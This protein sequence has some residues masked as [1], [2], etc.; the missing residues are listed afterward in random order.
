M[1]GGNFIK[2]YIEEK[3][4]DTD[5]HIKNWATILMKQ[6][7]AFIFVGFNE[8]QAMHLVEIFWKQCDLRWQWEQEQKRKKLGD[9]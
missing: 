4:K 8:Q 5:E 3:Q 9:E 2:A 7:D 6:Y 1:N